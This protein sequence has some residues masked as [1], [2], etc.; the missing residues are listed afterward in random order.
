MLMWCKFDST[1]IKF[2]ILNVVTQKYLYCYYR[3]TETPA[4]AFTLLTRFLCVCVCVCVCVCL[5]VCV[6]ERERVCETDPIA[7]KSKVLNIYH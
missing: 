5:C 7:V 6:C 3:T 2:E 4:V 1:I